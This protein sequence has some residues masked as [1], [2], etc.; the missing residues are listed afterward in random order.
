MK[1]LQITRLLQGTI[2]DNLPYD[3]IKNVEKQFLRVNMLKKQKES[4][5]RNTQ[6]PLNLL[7]D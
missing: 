6:D 3:T 5:R 1:P 4:I 2:A 7:L